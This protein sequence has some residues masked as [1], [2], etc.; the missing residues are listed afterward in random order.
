MNCPVFFFSFLLSGGGNVTPLPATFKHL[1]V[2]VPK[3][4]SE[5]VILPLNLREQKS[6]KLSEVHRISDDSDVPQTQNYY[7]STKSHVDE[8]FK[9]YNSTKYFT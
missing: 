4:L 1:G 9:L 5:T 2:L 3:T 8:C 6:M 7:Y